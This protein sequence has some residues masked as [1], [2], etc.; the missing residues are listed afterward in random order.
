MSLFSFKHSTERVGAIVDIGSASVL[1]AIVVSRPQTLFPTIVWSHREHA[2]LR[3]IDSVEQSAKAVM[4]A[5]MNAMLKFDGEGRRALS[6]YR[7]S[8][9]I[10]E[11][12]CSIAAPWSYTV[13]K[14]ITYSQDEAF[15]ITDNLIEELV[16]AALQ[17]ITAELNDNE[18]VN[19]LG[20]TVISRATL[21][22]QANGY[23]VKH[24]E[25]EKASTLSLNHAS[26]ITQEYLVEMINDMRQKLFPSA[27][28]RKISYMLMLYSV[29]GQLAMDT[30]DTCLVNVTY[31]ATEIGVVRDGIL[32]YS[33]H[34]P[35]GAFSLARQI[36]DITAV[37]LYE[38]FG[39]LH[40]ETP[41]SFMESLPSNQKEAVEAVFEAY[42]AEVTELF[43]ETG[44]DLSIPN[45]IYLHA[46]LM[47]EPLFKDLI[48]KAAKRTIKSD[49]AITLTTPLLLKLLQAE[50]E[51]TKSALPTDTA[52]MVSAQFF[53]KLGEWKDIEYL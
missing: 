48:E 47:S 38:A 11:L 18:S 49:P 9:H 44:D 31:E 21:D 15:E 2:P 45:H 4:T 24:P 25:E 10:S 36:A 17:K 40:T 33:T 37:P 8:S 42:I 22:I 30:N 52:M 23:R 29:V 27:E 5:F 12:L 19:D 43:H 34:V 50:G 46:D 13:T 51:A 20:L 6:E 3:N 41:Y 1:I 26:A 16:R 7:G 32:H 14:S 53:H 35:A 28:V 39:Y